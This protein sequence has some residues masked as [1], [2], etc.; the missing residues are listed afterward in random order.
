[1]PKTFD[2]AVCIRHWD[3]SETSQT[4]SLLARSHGLLRALAKGSRRPKA[5]FSGGLELLTLGRAGL[6]VKPATE[7]ALL[8]EW[9]LQEI[10]P[11]LRTSLRAHHA[12]L[13][14]ADLTHHALVDRDPHP[15]LFDALVTALR[16]L[17][18]PGSV[19][20]ALLRYQWS[21]LVETGHRPVVGAD[22]A[23][24][25]PLRPAAVY[26]FRPELGGLVMPTGGS[27]PGWP[28]RAQ[29][30]AVLRGLEGGGPM[31]G[32]AESVDRA[33]RLLA[34]CLRYVLGREPRT[35]PLL[36]GNRLPR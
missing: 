13:Y 6:I 10:F 9:D 25:E 29:T 36:F 4:V 15:A 2:Q 18:E 20:T 22:A 35:M 5:P 26:R 14:F 7:L 31:E 1:V 8:T 28:V 19:A 34:S 21:V 27:A 32:P 17:A 30:V 3:W 23:T 12:G 16:G 33:N 11:A 24:G